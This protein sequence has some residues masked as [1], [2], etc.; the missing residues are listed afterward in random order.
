M[1]NVESNL[2]FNPALRLLELLQTL[3]KAAKEGNL[4]QL[5]QVWGVALAPQLLAEK[6]AKKGTYHSPR[7]GVE[8]A[9]IHRRISMVGEL[10]SEAEASIRE[11]GLDEELYLQS[12]HPRVWQLMTPHALLSD[13]KAEPI[14]EAQQGL[15]YASDRLNGF[16]QEQR[17]DSEQLGEITK[18][19]RDALKMFE[20]VEIPVH[21][22]RI[23]S[24][25]LQTILDAIEMYQV[26]G[27]GGILEATDA[28]IGTFVL[29]H[30][31]IPLREQETIRKLLVE[32]IRWETI[33][34]AIKEMLAVKAL[35]EWTGEL[36]DAAQKL[37]PPE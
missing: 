34:P 35:V 33:W 17:V 36:A 26:T 28:G 21:A 9:T 32:K 14:S 11:K 12:W 3:E 30:G 27:V 16:P 23:L 37:L 20:E 1:S 8:T 5:F 24:R 15:R 22:S 19:L 2:G 7:P 29:H 4:S 13:W 10:A 6:S 18:E 25:R 31:H